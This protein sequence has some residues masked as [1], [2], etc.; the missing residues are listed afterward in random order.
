[1]QVQGKIESQP[2]FEFSEKNLTLKNCAFNDTNL[3][4]TNKLS[5]ETLQYPKVTISQLGLVGEDGYGGIIEIFNFEV[6]YTN[7]EPK[8][9]IEFN[10]NDFTTETS[11]N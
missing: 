4:D 10:T 9:K 2:F 8:E 11:R 5:D 1:M 7:T 3:G 6:A